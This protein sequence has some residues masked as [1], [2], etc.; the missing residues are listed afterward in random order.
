[1][2]VMNILI[3]LI[4][5][6]SIYL[7]FFKN[8]IVIF[9]EISFI[10]VNITEFF[11]VKRRLE[12]ILNKRYK[13]YSLILALILISALSYSFIK[14]SDVYSCISFLLIMLTVYTWNIESFIAYLKHN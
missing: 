8:F 12:N 11:S 10:V 7:G 9:L 3:K 4:R 6:Y 1:M 5:D 13:R 2:G 14:E